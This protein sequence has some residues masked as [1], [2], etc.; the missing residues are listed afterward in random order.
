MALEPKS[1]YI[2][3]VHYKYS[4]YFLKEW[5]SVG[6]N[7]S[8]KAWLFSESLFCIEVLVEHHYC[9]SVTPLKVLTK[10]VFHVFLPFFFPHSIS[11]GYF[12]I[13][14]SLEVDLSTCLVLENSFP[15]KYC[16]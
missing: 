5:E 9:S 12:C 16:I 3:M 7:K 14:S 11:C 13:L 4:S 10:C 6:R 8:L 2:N 15:S 1:P